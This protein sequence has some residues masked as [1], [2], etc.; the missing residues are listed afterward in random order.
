MDKLTWDPS[1]SSQTRPL[2]A[3]AQFDLMYDTRSDICLEALDEQ[4]GQGKR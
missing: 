3:L 1:T 2:H 4:V